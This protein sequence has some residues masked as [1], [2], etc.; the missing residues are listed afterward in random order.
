MQWHKQWQKQKQRKKYEEKYKKA[1]KQ[2]SVALFV[3]IIVG[4]PLISLLSPYKT[5][6]EQE[7]R[8]LESFPQL[9]FDSFVSKSFMT[10]FGN[11]VSDHIAF[12][13][14]WVTVKATTTTLVG[15]RDNQREGEDRVYLGKN[16]LIDDIKAPTKAIYESN[17]EAINKFAK[18]N[19]EAHISAPCSHSGGNRA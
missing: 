5:M 17:I 14:Q 4:L 9:T 12:R 3:L 18:K 1:Q 16:C 13:D 7:N 11:F 10:H 6:S 8:E 15:K 2:I 19:Q